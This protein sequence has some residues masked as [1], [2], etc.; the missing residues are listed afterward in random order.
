MFDWKVVRKWEIHPGLFLVTILIGLGLL[1]RVANLDRKVFWVDEVATAVRVAGYTTR[2]ITTQISDG[3]LLTPEDL[4]KFQRLNPDTPWSDTLRALVKSPEHAPLYFLIARLWT[5]SFGSSIAAIRSLSVVCS[6]I[7]L[8]CTYWLCLELFQAGVTG[9]VGVGLLAICPFLISYAQEARPYS[10]WLVTL[11]LSSG[12]LLRALRLNTRMSWS[13][14]GLTLAM[15]FYTS[16]L[17]LLVAVGYTLYAIAVESW[18][19]TQTVRNYAIALSCALIVFIPWLLVMIQH[20]ELLQTNT[21]WMREPVDWFPMIA[22]W[23]YSFAILFFDVPVST[24]M[25]IALVEVLVASIVWGVIGYA[26]YFL[27]A[28]ASR[29]I[30]LF[31]YM[32]CIP[33]LFTLFLLALTQHGLASTAPRYL[34]PCQLGILL[35]VIYLL[36]YPCQFSVSNPISQNRWKV[37]TATLLSLCILSGLFNLTRTP[38]YQKSRN[39]H[40]FAI[41]ATLNQA[42]N[43]ILLAEREQAMDIASL[44][45]SLDPKNKIQIFP[46]AQ[47]VSEL[48]HCQDVFLFNPSESLLQRLQAPKHFRLEEVYKPQGL[49]THNEAAL[50]LWKVDRLSHCHPVSNSKHS[51]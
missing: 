11:L 8:P 19:I 14:Y 27:R 50:S 39:R 46:S 17:S 51:A 22:V 49:I 18:Q 34:F 33:T 13:L 24:T 5:Q 15:S 28:M 10:L 31:V 1:F 32:L 9:W 2:E 44:S 20:W 42:S 35:A 29:R 7:A 23:F 47:L 40:N 48:E 26:L 41:A 12:L 37:M 38:D 25:P 21:T 6:L 36:S 4:L 16:L 3:R 43:P 45:H 30:W